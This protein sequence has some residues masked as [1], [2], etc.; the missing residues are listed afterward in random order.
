MST[1]TLPT[2]LQ[3]ILNL[4]TIQF[5]HNDGITD[6]TK[7]LDQTDFSSEI[8][9]EKK[10]PIPDVNN[11]FT[12]LKNTGG[13]TSK[14]GVLINSTLTQDAT[15]IIPEMFMKIVSVK[16]YS[17]IY[18]VLTSKS[19]DTTFKF[20]KST[21][22][23]TLEEKTTNKLGITTGIDGKERLIYKILQSVG[24]T[25]PLSPEDFD[26]FKN[27]EFNLKQ[28]ILLTISNLLTDIIKMLPAAK[29]LLATA[30]GAWGK[31]K[32]QK[33]GFEDIFDSPKIY[34]TQG[35]VTTL[36]DAFDKNLITNTNSIPNPFSATGLNSLNVATLDP[37]FPQSMKE[38]IVPSQSGG[39]KNQKHRK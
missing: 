17:E 1:I 37:T 26:R 16:A 4:N 6:I 36:T 25:S 19:L 24:I 27:T 30:G 34:N 9:K 7:V 5:S 35:L 33:G 10:T 32:K 8:Q 18:N 20:N 2:D 13:K 38:D 23:Y 3:T 29:E 31:Q 21:G 11:L 28:A 39:K 22:D 14:T 15:V 12:S